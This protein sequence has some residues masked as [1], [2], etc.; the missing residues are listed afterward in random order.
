MAGAVAKFEQP[1]FRTEREVREQNRLVG[2]DADIKKSVAQDFDAAFSFFPRRDA[3]CK[4]KTF[5]V[6]GNAVAAA[7][8]VVN[9]NAGCK[10]ID[11]GRVDTLRDTNA[12]RPGRYAV[13]ILGHTT[14]RVRFAVATA[15]R[16][17]HRRAQHGGI[18]NGRINT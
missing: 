18:D 11:P 10:G 4:G 17:V 7:D 14:V 1:G 13:V 12:R 2:Q 3:F 6:V 8:R 9:F 5:I 16:I 15:D